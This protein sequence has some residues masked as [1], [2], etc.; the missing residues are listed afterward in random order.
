MGTV[1]TRKKHLNSYFEFH[2]VLTT[3]I[4]ELFQKFKLPKS[5]SN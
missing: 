5:Y 3:Y 1:I 4:F 2:S